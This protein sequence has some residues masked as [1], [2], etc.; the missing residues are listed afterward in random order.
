MSQKV[1]YGLHLAFN[2]NPVL[3]QWLT[4]VQKSSLKHV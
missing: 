3:G 4:S 2:H 1:D